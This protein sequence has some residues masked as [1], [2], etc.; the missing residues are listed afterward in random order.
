MCSFV[1]TYYILSVLVSPASSHCGLLKGKDHVLQG[2]TAF[3][4][5]SLG[6]GP[7]K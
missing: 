6:R 4:Y 3:T 7:S 5:L 2:L 1:V